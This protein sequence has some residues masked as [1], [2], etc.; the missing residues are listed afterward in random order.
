MPPSHLT[1]PLQVCMELLQLDEG[2]CW[3]DHN[4]LMS[5]WAGGDLQLQCCQLGQGWNSWGEAC[6]KMTTRFCDQGL[7]VWVDHWTHG[8]TIVGVGCLCT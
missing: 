3:V 5:H 2:C 4:S 8:K 7:T 6:A 1:Q